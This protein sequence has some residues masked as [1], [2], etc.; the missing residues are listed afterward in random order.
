M[1]AHVHGQRLG[2]RDLFI[3]TGGIIIGLA[4]NEARKVGKESVPGI[5]EVVTMPCSEAETRMDKA[6]TYEKVSYVMDGLGGAAIVTSV[7]LF[8]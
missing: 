2:G 5:G 4:K 6:G 7:I 1:R 3:V 8:L